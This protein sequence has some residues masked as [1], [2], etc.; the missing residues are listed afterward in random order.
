MTAD[1]ESNPPEAMSAAPP[2]TSVARIHL[3]A[4]S[5][6]LILGTIVGSLAA[7]QLV[8]PD[9][10]SGSA[11]TT[12]GR[13]APAARVLLTDGWI[14]LG[15]LGLSYLAI[16]RVTGSNVRR[17]TLA[18][19]GAAVIA[20]GAFVGA[21][22]I[23]VGLQSG[24][25]GQESPVW[26]RAILLIGYALSATAIVSTARVNKDEL[27]ATGW[28]LTAAPVWL[29]LSGIVAVIPAPDGIPS[30]IQMAFA[31]AGMTGLF[32]VTAS[33][34]L[35]YFVFTAL[36]DTDPSAPR[37]LATL[38]FWSLTLVWANLA[39]VHL[40]FSPTPDWYET[41]AVAFAI[42]ALI[43]LITIATDLGLMLRGRA[44][45][46]TDRGSLRYAVIASLS[47]S[48][49][50]VVMLLLTWRSTSSIAQ[51]STWVNGLDVLIVL[52]GGSFA[53]F[54]GASVMR[55]GRSG[56]PSAHIVLSVLGLLAMG[57]ALLVG[58][59]V[60]GFTWAAGPASQ[61]YANSGDAW[62]LTVDASEPFLW[63]A[64]MGAVVFALA[65]IIYA[66]TVGRG[67]PAPAPEL[68]PPIDYDLE[69]EGPPRYAT[70]TRLMWGAIA[71]WAF[72]AVMTW[73]LPAVDT[74]DREATILADT[75]RTYEAGTPEALGRELY[76]SEGC[77]ECHTQQV[78][79]VG[80]DVGL[81]PVSI[82]GDY[83]HEQPPLLGS[84]R[85]GPDLMHYAGLVEFFDVVIVQAKLERPRT[86]VPWSTMPSYSYLSDEDLSALISYMETLR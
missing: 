12:Y 49:A 47:L 75:S 81:G 73:L 34:G 56:G 1:T 11:F 17:R 60:V 22:G 2:G 62:R 54:A 64:A 23:L 76:I 65:Q 27:G 41:L 35:L 28:Y 61:T 51:F 83:A 68:G 20:F 7:L 57:G 14:T 32:V 77:I 30:T 86:V 69:F 21:A 10:L 80:T 52:G 6:F 19:A 59:V 46:L 48:V 78:R 84:Y 85:F 24:I 72:A 9:L 53:I 18:I 55:G 58:G 82:A 3:T 43:P 8:L 63:V 25:V 71:V 16:V 66:A 39:A 31:N 45:L 74:T 4:G 33:V 67:E 29:T 40:I 13:L 70:W 79:P 37:P 15:I 44:E 26:A 42:G 50:T 38:G 36:T 5:V